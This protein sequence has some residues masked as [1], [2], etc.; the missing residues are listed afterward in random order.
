MTTLTPITH[1]SFT[2]E[3]L[4]PEDA[5]SRV[6]HAFTDMG[7]R[8]RW[9]FGIDGWIIHEIRAP[10]AVIPGAVESSRF[11]PPGGA[12]VITNDTTLFEVVP[13]ARLIFAY[14]MTID[15]GPLSSSLSTVEFRPEG[16]GTRLTFTEQ[17]AYH[18]GFAD[19]REAGTRQSFERLARELAS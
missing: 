2:I 7:A 8:R 5:P 13:D 14:V 17:G 3:R 11:S 12:V 4:Y 9:F 10:E 19:G 1:H 6:F 16:R 15:G 18:E